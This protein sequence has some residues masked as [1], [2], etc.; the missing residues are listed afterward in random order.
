[1]PRPSRARPT[2]AVCLC[3]AVA[4]AVLDTLCFNWTWPD[5]KDNAQYYLAARSLADGRGYASLDGP[6]PGPERRTPV[7]LPL[8]LAPVL[9]LTGGGVYAAQVAIL[10]MHVAAVGA[11]FLWLRKATERSVFWCAAATVVGWFGGWML[12]YSSTIMA[13]VPYAALSLGVLLLLDGPRSSRASGRWLAAGLLAGF[14]YLVRSVGLSLIL[15]AV[16]CGAFRRDWK[17]AG[18]FAAGALCVAVPWWIRNLRV[19]GVPEVYL[20]QAGGAGG[21]GLL[22]MALHN[23]REALPGYFGRLLPGAMFYQ[24]FGGKNLLAAAVGTSG[25]LAVKIVLLGLVLAGWVSAV[26]RLTLPGLYWPLYWL[27]LSVFTV[28]YD[29][30]RYVLPIVP[31]AALFLCSSASAAA[32]RALALA[33]RSEPGARRGGEAAVGLLAGI[34]LLLAGSA[35]AARFAKQA[36]FL[37]EKP[38][39]AIRYLSTGNPYDAAFARFAEAG[40]WIAENAPPDAWVVSRVP[41]QMTFFSGRRGWRYD[42][43]E[44]PGTNVWDRIE[45]AA[46]NR[47]VLIVQDAFPADSTFGRSRLQVLDP[48][49]EAHRSAL[50]PAFATQAP[51]TR[52]WRA[53]RDAAGEVRRP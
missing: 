2:T 17:R 30:V 53:V 19:A 26:R 1:M 42:F 21:A 12:F 33:G 35:A 32:A 40:E 36:R 37:G 50:E 39:A 3:L 25:A 16:L 6:A 5:G 48:A 45:R 20:L 14:A 8:L 43:A 41:Q 10:L 31:V 34:V 13:D 4:A 44:M 23:L 38:W 18:W 15:A 52:V 24:L 27:I 11:A 28:D 51:T 7:G 49:L 22:Q 9:R 29:S 47:E 46:R